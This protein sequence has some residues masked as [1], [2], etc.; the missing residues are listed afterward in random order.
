MTSEEGGGVSKSEEEGEEEGGV[1][2]E[3]ARLG[4]A[5]ASSGKI[6]EKNSSSSK[7]PIWKYAMR[8]VG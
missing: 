7:A 5:A 4:D 6:W 1:D 2:V 8:H 3:L